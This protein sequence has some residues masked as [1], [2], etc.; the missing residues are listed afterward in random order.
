MSGTT[1][2][3]VMRPRRSSTM[4]VAMMAG[5]EQPKP[6]II[7]MKDLP[8]SPMLVHEV[9]HDERRAGHVAGVLETGDGEEEDH[10][11]GQKRDDASHAADDAVD[12]ERLSQSGL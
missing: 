3:V 6:M 12:E 2:M 8:W 7:G 1:I 9:V 10:D 11:V 4:R 5:T